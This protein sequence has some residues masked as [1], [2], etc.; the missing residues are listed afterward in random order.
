MPHP[1]GG[2]VEQVAATFASLG[3]APGSLII[4]AGCGS[5][6]YAASLHER[7]YRVIGIDRSVALIDRARERNRGAAFVS[8]DLLTWTPP[9]APGAVLCR[10]VLNDL[11]LEDERR[12]AFEQ[13]SSWLPPDGI[14]LADVREW[15]S[16]AARYANNSKNCTTVRNDRCELRF[17][18]ETA[19]NPDDRLMLVRERYVGVVDGVEVEETYDFAMRCWTKAEIRDYAA[20][21]GFADV[22]LRAGRQVGIAPDRIQVVA[23]R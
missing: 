22:Q 5:G 1:A 11:L 6:R 14:L 19:L 7:G 12:R 8:A 10:G 4:D 16:T 21:A 3:V 13:F 20:T 18:T 15:E 2:S 9:E 23:L 17:E